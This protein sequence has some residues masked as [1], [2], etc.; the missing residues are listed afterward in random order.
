MKHSVKL[1]VADLHGQ[2]VPL[3]SIGLNYAMPLIREA[4]RGLTAQ[5]TVGWQ[6]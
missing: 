6:N 4:T 5:A 2:T 1:D 3:L